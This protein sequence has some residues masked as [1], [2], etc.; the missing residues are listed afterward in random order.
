MF[1]RHRQRASFSTYGILGMAAVPSI[2]ILHVSVLDPV[3]MRRAIL[4]QRTKHLSFTVQRAVR[5]SHLARIMAA[6]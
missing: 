6:L 4:Y 2:L 3:G 1:A 5:H